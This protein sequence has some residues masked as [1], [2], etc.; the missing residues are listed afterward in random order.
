MKNRILKLSMQ[1][2][3][4]LYFAVPLLIVQILSSILSHSAL[5]GKFR[6]QYDYSVGQSL[7]QAVPLSCLAYPLTVS[8]KLGIKSLR[9]F[10]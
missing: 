3:M 1:K 8:T 9:R 2:R 4:M 7:T 6:K 10:N 5:L